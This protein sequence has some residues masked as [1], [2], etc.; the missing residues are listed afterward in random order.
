MYSPP[1]TD[2]GVRPGN[3]LLSV[4]P[5]NPFSPVSATSRLRKQAVMANIRSFG[6]G[7]PRVA[8]GQLQKETLESAPAIPPNPITTLGVI[9]T[10]ESKDSHA[11][12]PP[13]ANDGTSTYAEQLQAL[14]LAV[15]SL[16]DVLTASGKTTA[17]ST[18]AKLLPSEFQSLKDENAKL[19]QQMETLTQQVAALKEPRATPAPFAPVPLT[20]ARVENI[21]RMVDDKQLKDTPRTSKATEKFFAD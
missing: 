19:H 3:D 12:S 10:E 11:G 20:T 15:H 16:Q 14:S 1:K 13:V 5:S 9:T 7:S 2:F 8:H 17:P 6:G 18:P 4:R 21:S